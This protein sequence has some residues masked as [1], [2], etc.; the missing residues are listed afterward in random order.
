MEPNQEKEKFSHVALQKVQRTKRQQLSHIP[1][2]KKNTR[3][4]KRDKKKKNSLQKI[5]LT[6]KIILGEMY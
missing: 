3:P 6:R 2:T 4:R 5:Y 1:K